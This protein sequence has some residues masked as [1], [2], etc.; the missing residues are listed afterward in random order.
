VDLDRT[1]RDGEA[2]GNF[3]VAQPT[4][5]EFEHLRLPGSQFAGARRALDWQ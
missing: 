4:E 1:F 2:I 5:D 3:S